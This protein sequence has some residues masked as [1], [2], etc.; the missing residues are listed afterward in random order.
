MPIPG[1]NLKTTIKDWLK[2][3]AVGI[4]GTAL[5]L[6]TLSLMVRLFGKRNYLILTGIAV[7]VSILHNFAWHTKWTWADRMSDGILH[8]VTA[9]LRFN[10]T[11]GAISI[12]GNLA[13]M[14]LFVGALGWNVQIANLAAIVSCSLLNFVVTDRFVFGKSPNT[15]ESEA[16]EISLVTS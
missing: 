6:V 1:R 12:L 13:L 9:L 5:Q 14:R 7:E 15:S 10:L 3:N 4:M 11:T 16:S 2:F 8:K